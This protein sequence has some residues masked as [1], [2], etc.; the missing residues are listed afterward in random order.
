[1]L[2]D[3]NRS[4][5]LEAVR[6]F[7]KQAH[8][9]KSF[10]PGVDWVPCAGRVY[11]PE[12]MEALVDAALDFWLTA[13]RFNDAFEKKLA[14]FLGL[15]F[16]LTCNSGSSANLLAIAALTSPLL[17]ERALKPGDEAVTVAAG[18]PTTV[19]PLLL[20]GITPVFVDIAIP[21]YNI[22]AE[23]IEGAITPK[24]K[25]IVLAHTL[26]NP[27]DLNEVMR[28]A[29]KYNLWVVEDCCDALGSTYDGRRVGA[30]GDIA[31]FSFYPAHPITMGEGGA[32]VTNQPLLKR[33]LASVR[34]WGRD[35]FCAP[36]KENTC[37]KR[38][39]W[40]LGEL[41][42]GYDHKYIYSHLGF[43]FKITDMQAAVGSAQL[44]R[45]PV[46]L[47]ARKKNF[48]FLK[49]AFS[50]WEE[51]FV[52]PAPTHGATPS[53]FGFPLTVR[54]NAPFSR[55]ELLRFL[56][57]RRIGTRLLFGGNLTRQPYFRG[58]NFRVSGDLALTER[59]MHQTFWIG[60]YPGLT[61]AML[62]YAVQTF[63]EFLKR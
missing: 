25:L 55:L 28:L 22:R 63:G 36:G 41:P 46:F 16:A 48:A 14:D 59:V 45:L 53:W 24:T 11:G 34:D 50:S 52:L 54:D 37:G 9:G 21:N 15:R 51:F 40:Q 26:G 17:G 42:K 12:E 3:L 4:Q 31:T 7:H 33:I 62:D 56:D 5:I 27:F 1:M 19:N 13:G 39:D 57:Q 6:R 32:V 38:F 2:V 30:F 60:C 35:C 10:S 44:D 18:F 43:N 29:K 23:K 20:Y 58:R 8:A 61:E 47:E 49:E